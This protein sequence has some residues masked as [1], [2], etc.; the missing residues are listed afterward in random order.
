MEWEPIWMTSR[1]ALVMKMAGS[2][3]CL[4]VSEK[5][6]EEK[7]YGS[8]IPGIQLNIHSLFSCLTISGLC[9]SAIAF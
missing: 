5:I 6:E 2:Q 1:G 8:R 4:Q 9:I 7:G 3:V